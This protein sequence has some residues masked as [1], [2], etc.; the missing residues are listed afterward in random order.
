MKF[1]KKLYTYSDKAWIIS[2][3]ISIYLVLALNK[4]KYP[5]ISYDEV[6]FGNMALGIYNDYFCYKLGKIPYHI[7]TYIGGLKAYIYYF[8]FK[9]FG[10]SIYSIRIPLIVLG[11]ISLAIL[12]KLVKKITNNNFIAFIITL[13]LATDP[14]YIIQ[15]HFDLGPTV[16]EMFIKCTVLYLLNNCFI[17]INKKN[18]VL[19]NIFLFLGLFNKLTFIWF[20]NAIFIGI[21]ICYIYQKGIKYNNKSIIINKNIWYLLCA[22]SVY[23]IYFC[24]MYIKFNVSSESAG[25]SLI[26]RERFKYVFKGI[27]QLI[28]GT[29]FPNQ[30]FTPI[31]SNLSMVFVGMILFILVMGFVAFIKDFSNNNKIKENCYY[32]FFLIQLVA[33][34]GQIFIVSMADKPWHIYSIYPYLWILVAISIKRLWYYVRHYKKMNFVAAILVL[35][36][37]VYHINIQ[38]NVSY[39][40]KVGEK[41]SNTWSRTITTPAIYELIEYAK[42]NKDKPLIS[43][44]WGMHMQLKTFTGNKS[45]SQIDSLLINKDTTQLDWIF[46]NENNLYITHGDNYICFKEAQ[47]N[48]FDYLKSN[49]LKPEL[50][51]EIKYDND[52]VY[53]LWSVKREIISNEEYNHPE[54]HN[55][56][57]KYNI[58]LLK[59]DTNTVEIKGWAYKNEKNDENNKFII[60]KSQNN[61]YTYNVNEVIRED[62]AKYFNNLNL[63]NSGFIGKIKTDHLDDGEYSVEILIDDGKTGEYITTSRKVVIKR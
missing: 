54:N 32:I 48:F 8:I 55:S 17:N 15:H 35:F 30:W 22:Y 62:V 19:L 29:V 38:L 26:L 18:I 59:Q 51:K 36:M 52:I 10:V 23:F 27:Y 31:K 37:A 41:N 9:F 2:I 39:I 14:T 57:I 21:I 49:Y 5:G 25:I 60:F 11:A 40:S 46:Q 4:L 3:P 53:K 56:N 34:I 13:C 6:N 1:K 45:Y 42:Q 33:I 12:F 24:T 44:D 63:R 58:D 47:V 28:A 50:V 16:L 7:M 61:K 20:I 43:T